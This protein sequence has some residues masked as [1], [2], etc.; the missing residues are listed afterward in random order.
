[1][2]LA[3]PMC[4]ADAPERLIPVIPND[5]L[6]ELIFNTNMSIEAQ[7]RPDGWEYVQIE[8]WEDGAD[9]TIYL[10]WTP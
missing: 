4:R 7:V 9:E 1:M 8:F 2:I 10:E 6:L 5:L 3:G